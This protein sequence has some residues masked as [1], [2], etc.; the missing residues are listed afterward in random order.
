MVGDDDKIGFLAPPLEVV[1]SGYLD[2]RRESKGERYDGFVVSNVEELSGPKAFVQKGVSAE[3]LWFQ[4]STFDK[5]SIPTVT[6]FPGNRGSPPSFPIISLL[7]TRVRR[8]D[9]QDGLRITTNSTRQAKKTT[10]VHHRTLA[11]YICLSIAKGFDVLSHYDSLLRFPSKLNSSGSTSTIGIAAGSP[12]KRSSILAHCKFIKWAI[13]VTSAPAAAS[14]YACLMISARDILGSA[15]G[16]ANAR[17]VAWGKLGG[18]TSAN[19]AV[20]TRFWRNTT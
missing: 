12:P 4:I 3:F 13:L 11:S 20:L 19:P 5:V 16:N 8:Q 18:K 17:R 6:H 15:R 1:F 14:V 9:G 7:R 10:G 2:R